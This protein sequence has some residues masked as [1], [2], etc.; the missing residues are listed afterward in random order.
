MNHTFTNR[1]SLAL[2]L[3]LI[4]TLPTYA[5]APPPNNPSDLSKK[6]FRRQQRTERRRLRKIK[7]QQ[8]RIKRIK[9]FLNSRRGQ[10]FLGRFFRDLFSCKIIPASFTRDDFWLAAECSFW[11][12]LAT[13]LLFG[14]LVGLSLLTGT[15][16]FGLLGIVAILMGGM[17]AFLS[18]FTFLIGIF[19]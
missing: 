13:A 16:G 8:R 14:I 11:R 4:I 17:L 15:M 12:L 1:I 6:E 10:R 5:D 19:L 3:F 7:R 9:R 18:F 2:L